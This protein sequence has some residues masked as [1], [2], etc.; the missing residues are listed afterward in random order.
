MR[1]LLGL[2]GLC[3]MVACGADEAE[4]SASPDS[5]EEDGFC[6]DISA[7]NTSEI[8]PGG[9][10]GANGALFARIITDESEDPHNPNY[11]AKVTYVLENLDVGGSPRY[12]ESDNAGEILATLGAG[13]WRVQLSN[14]R[15]AGQDCYND[16]SFVIE[17]GKTTYLCLD[18]NCQ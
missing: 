7:A 8:V 14:T 13:N 4:D 15:V 16:Q 1:H 9:A 5:A 18:V 12:G 6:A 3:S 2:L 11:V 17:A 10:S